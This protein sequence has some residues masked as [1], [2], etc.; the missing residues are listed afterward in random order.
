MVQWQQEQQKLYTKSASNS[1]NPVN[2]NSKPLHCTDFCTFS[3]ERKIE[4]IKKN[5]KN[6]TQH[7]HSGICLFVII[8]V[9]VYFESSAGNVCTCVSECMCVCMVCCICCCNSIWL[10]LKWMSNRIQVHKIEI[11]MMLNFDVFVFVF[12]KDFISI[13]IRLLDDVR[14]KNCIY[15]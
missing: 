2:S 1:Y 9:N 3:S 5:D 15:V 10:I 11:D 4:I 14:R 8:V 6:Y 13:V 7:H 12:C